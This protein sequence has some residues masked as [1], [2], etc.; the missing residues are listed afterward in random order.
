M[1]AQAQSIV[2][3][4]DAELLQ[5]QADLWRHSLC[6]LTSMA[7]KCAVKLGIPTAIHNLGGATTLPNLITELSLPPPKLPFLRRLMRLLVTSG[8]FAADESTGEETYHLNLLSRLLVDGVVVDGDAHQK[9]IVL[10]ANSRR[11]VDTALSLADWFKKDMAAPKSPFEELH[12]VALFDESMALLDPESDKLI[13]EA[14]AAHDNLGISQ[15][16][17]QCPDLFN[18]L[19]S[20]TD[21]CGGD[22]TTAKAI[23]KAFPHI[24]CTVLDLPRVI[25]NISVDGAI[26]YVAGDMFKFIPPSQAVMLKLVLHFWN[27][28]DC[29][30]ILTQC[31][32]AIASRE[33]G[34]KV[35]IIDIVIGSSSK[36]ILETE[37][38][39]DMLMLTMTNGQQRDENEWRNIF[40]KAGFS[41]YRIVKKLGP[42]GIFEVYP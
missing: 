36:T 25:K 3:P 16:L 2:V 11:Y 27:D 32:K 1:A 39:M 38:L 29:V 17:Q 14:V 23:V 9:A 33:A 20:L 41:G 7:L 26:N 10:A 19:Q 21:C 8:V 18:G 24:K 37:L 22:G 30:K 6:Y 28:E 15:V 34:G 12:G 5:A 40:M 31:R 13:A 35:I 42:R 4:T